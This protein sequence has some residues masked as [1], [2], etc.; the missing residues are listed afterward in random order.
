MC[1]FAR[2]FV[3][4]VSL[5]LSPPPPDVRVS[6]CGHLCRAAYF[7]GGGLQLRSSELVYT[8][9]DRPRLQTEAM[10]TVILELGVITHNFESYGVET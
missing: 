2:S 9:V 1:G 7:V 8:G 10:G 4:V 6:F 3:F 5:L